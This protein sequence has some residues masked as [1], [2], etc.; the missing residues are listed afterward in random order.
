VQV[1][2]SYAD[3]GSFGFT[4]RSGIAGSYGVLFLV[5]GGIST[6]I[7]AVAA[8]LYILTNSAWGFFSSHILTSI[9]CFVF[10][11]I[12]ILTGVRWN[13]TS[14]WFAFPFWL[15]ILTIFSCIFEPFVLL[16]LWR[17]QIL[18]PWMFYLCA[19]LDDAFNI[20]LFSQDPFFQKYLLMSTDVLHILRGPGNTVAN[21]IISSC[22]H[23][24][25][26]CGLSFL[27]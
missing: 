15:R 6:L 1:L 22:P 20:S 17:L 14:F 3:F 10:L 2:L 18:S 21:K 26:I 4:H 25:Q 11:M 24:I 5:S 23:S 7:S 19:R 27:Y 12:D 16:F 13:L 8:L 9:C